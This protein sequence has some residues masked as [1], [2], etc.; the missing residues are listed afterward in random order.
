MQL[1]DFDYHL[2][3]ELIAQEALADRAASRM[4]VVHRER[5]CWED[6]TFRDLP[7]TCTRAIA[8][9]PTIPASFQRVSSAIAPGCARCPLART[10]LRFANT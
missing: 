2:P 7:D 8:W 6:R 9:W 1:A 10:T 4:L 5:G 3:E